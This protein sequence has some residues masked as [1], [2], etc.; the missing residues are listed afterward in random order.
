VPREEQF[1][2]PSVAQAGD[3]PDGVDVSLPKDMNLVFE[4]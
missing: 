3:K 1:L 2:A 4:R